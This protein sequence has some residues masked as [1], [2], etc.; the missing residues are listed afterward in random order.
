MVFS[1]PRYLSKLVDGLGK[2]VISEIIDLTN[3]IFGKTSTWPYVT[4]QIFKA[5]SNKIPDCNLGVRDCFQTERRDRGNRRREGLTD[6]CCQNFYL[7]CKN[8]LRLLSGIK[9]LIALAL[10]NKKIHNAG[11]QELKILIREENVIW[12]IVDWRTKF[13]VKL[14]FDRSWSSRFSSQ[15]SNKIPDCNLRVSACF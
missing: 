2:N 8:L 3:Q 13:L 15:L 7:I 12:Q 10:R 14:Q 11:A 1:K 5:I 9:K 6:A 4:R